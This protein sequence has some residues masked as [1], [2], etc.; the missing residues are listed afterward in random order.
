MKYRGSLDVH[1]VLV[2]TDTIVLPGNTHPLQF[3]NVTLSPGANFGLLISI[4]L[5]FH[6]FMI[7]RGLV[8]VKP[9]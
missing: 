1:H 7:R 9:S 6:K 2:S 8:L 4:C 3:V 5:I